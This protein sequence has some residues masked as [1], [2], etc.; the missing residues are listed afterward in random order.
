VKTAQNAAIKWIKLKVSSQTVTLQKTREMLRTLRLL[1]I[2][3]TPGYKNFIKKK[4]DNKHIIHAKSYFDVVVS[5]PR[6]S[7]FDEN[8]QLPSGQ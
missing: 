2:F 5:K 8:D 4:H 1:L 6:T 7:I 3:R